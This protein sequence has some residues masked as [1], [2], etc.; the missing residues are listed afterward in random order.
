MTVW[1]VSAFRVAKLCDKPAHSRFKQILFFD[2]IRFKRAIFIL[3]IIKC[4]KLQN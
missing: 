2:G 1:L 4:L 3:L